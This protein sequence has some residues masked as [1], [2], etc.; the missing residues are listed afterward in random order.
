MR[1]L[2]REGPHRE[3]AAAHRRGRWARM[4]RAAPAAAFRRARERE[5]AGSACYFFFSF[6]AA[7]FSFSV[8]VGCFFS[9]FF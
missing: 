9:L 6:L 5:L 2:A 4:R 7:R 3:A 1:S 8:L